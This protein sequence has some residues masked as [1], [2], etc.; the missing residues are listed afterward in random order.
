MESQ[1]ISPLNLRKEQRS[2]LWG[3]DQHAVEAFSFDGTADDVEL[4]MTMAPIEMLSTSPQNNA[5]VTDS[6]RQSSKQGKKRRGS[7]SDL[8]CIGCVLTCFAAISSLRLEGDRP[9]KRKQL[10]RHP[11]HDSGSQEYLY[12]RASV[13]SKDSRVVNLKILNPFHD[14]SK[15]R[16]FASRKIVILKEGETNG[17]VKFSLNKR[18]RKPTSAPYQHA[19]QLQH[20]NGFHGQFSGGQ[21]IPKSPAGFGSNM[22]LDHIDCLLW[23]FCKLQPS[24]DLVYF[25]IF[26]IKLLS[27]LDEH[28]FHRRTCSWSTLRPW[29]R[30]MT[31]LD[32]LLYRLQQH[33]FWT[34][35]KSHNG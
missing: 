22:I 19:F 8:F 4:L 12:F 16:H 15:P 25:L 14:E 18:N 20:S 21:R 6:L 2:R 30:V 5:M 23:Q 28:C 26:Q 35:R 27:A 31:V 17:Y 32:T 34:T 33:T 24:L 7:K 11:S 29:Q 1:S 10:Q 13:P 3:D 9:D